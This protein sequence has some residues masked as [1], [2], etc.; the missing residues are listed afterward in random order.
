MNQSSDSEAD[1]RAT[2]L[3]PPAPITTTSRTGAPIATIG[4]FLLL[5][6]IVL[7]QARTLLLPIVS[8]AVIAMML[9]PLAARTRRWGVPPWL[10]AVGVVLAILAALNAAIIQASALIIDWVEKAP[11]ITASIKA[12]LRVLI[13]PFDALR[14]LENTLSQNAEHVGLTGLADLAQ[15][16]LAFLTPALGELAV[17]FAALFFSLTGYKELRDYLILVIGDRETRLRT[18]RILNNI[19]KDL[20]RYAT[21]VTIINFGLGLITALIAYAVGLPNPALW[22]VI[23]FAL[24]FLPYIGPAILF[25]AL[26]GAGLVVF[27]SL[28]HAILAP[29]LLIA[30]DTL[31]GYIVAPNVLG[32]QLTLSPGLVFLALVFWAWLWGPVGAVLATPLL[33]VAT[34]TMNHVFPKHVVDLPG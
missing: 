20:T 4:I 1:V 12:K 15:P 19:E 6:A 31:S 14:N 10:F 32:R 25:A 28:G 18:L 24:E 9:G 2:E 5:L 33:I 22:G 3:T 17:F 16:A 23:A 21:T 29:L 13:E 26:F 7:D 8:A 11:E 30:I 27:D 34:V